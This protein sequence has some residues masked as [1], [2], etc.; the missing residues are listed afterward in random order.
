MI[1]PRVASPPPADKADVGE[2]WKFAQQME[3]EFW[4]SLDEATFHAQEAGY[5]SL[6]GDLVR[7]A[8][9]RFGIRDDIRILQI[10]CAVEDAV[11]HFPYGKRFAIDPLADFYI[12]HFE[13]SRNPS[14]TYFTANGEAIPFVSNVFDLIICNNVLDHVLHPEKVLRDV[15]RTLK[16]G[17]IFFLSVDVYPEATY[18]QRVAR[19]ASG[20]VIDPCHPHTFT[21]KTLTGLVDTAGFQ[22]LT[23]GEA[24][25]GKGDE[26]VRYCLTL[27]KGKGLGER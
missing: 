18:S 19:E 20:V 22:V 24:A 6:A 1:E 27:L 12:Q 5:Q 15:R 9:T 17:G 25:A 23:A 14:V 13:R 21:I 4:L 26:A 3:R 10:G 2:R 8:R 11:M 16:S 7:H